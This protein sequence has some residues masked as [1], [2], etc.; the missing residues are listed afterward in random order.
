[1]HWIKGLYSGTG[2]TYEDYVFLY[3]LTSLL[4]PKRIAEVGTHVGAASIVMAR[5]LRDAEA[6]GH[7]WSCDVNPGFLKRAERQIELN[8]L[9]RYISLLEGGAPVLPP[10]RFDLSFIDGDHTYDAVQ[11]DLAELLPRS[12]VV[13]LHDPQS[14]PDGVGRA[15]IE[16]G[17]GLLLNTPPGVRWCEWKR[18][19]A[20]AN[21]FYLFSNDALGGL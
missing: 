4:Q 17:K 1:M 20:F 2:C 21:G 10:G 6:E 19:G 3:G 11:R 13:V 8:G 7:I 14:N 16:K 9:S 15:C 12:R 18:Q 5:A